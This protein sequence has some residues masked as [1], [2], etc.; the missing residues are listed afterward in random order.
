MRRAAWALALLLLAARGGLGAPAPANCISLEGERSASWIDKDQVTR[1]FS[2][3][4][5]IV[6]WEAYARITLQWDTSVDIEHVY[7]A[8]SLGQPD[9][10]S[11]VV[12][13]DAERHASHSFLVAGVGYEAMTERQSLSPRITCAS[14]DA[15]GV[16][17]P[18]PP[19]AAACDLG[20]AF[21]VVSAWAT[22][23]AVAL[24]FS[25][26]D[27]GREVRLVFWGQHGLALLQP[28][29]A[30]LAA[31][32]DV[33]DDAVLTLTLGAA[34]AEPSPPLRCV[35]S[36]ADVRTVSFQLEPPPR[37]PP[38]I[39]CLPSALPRPPPAPASTAAL[40][41]PLPLASSSLAGMAEGQP[42]TVRPDGNCALGGAASIARS[43]RLPAGRAEA[44]VVVQLGARDAAAAVVLVRARGAMLGV[45]NV[46]G[47]AVLRP[48][49]DADG[50]LLPFAVE[51]GAYAFAF[52]LHGLEGIEL[53]SMA[54]ER[55]A[56]PSLAPPPPP[57]PPPPPRGARQSEADRAAAAAEGVEEA[58]AAALF[59][60]LGGAA[61]ALCW[62]HRALVGGL[63]ARPL[64]R[65]GMGADLSAG[66]DNPNVGLFSAEEEGR[67]ACEEARV[68]RQSARGAARGAAAAGRSGSF[69]MS[70]GEEHAAAKGRRGARLAASEQDA[71]KAELREQRMAQRSRAAKAARGMLPCGSSRKGAEGSKKTK[72]EKAPAV[73]GGSALTVEE[74][75][76]GSDDALASVRVR[77]L[78]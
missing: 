70:E 49:A 29:G 11:L 38:R 13:L 14:A 51:A 43:R 23:A 56:A 4:F 5:H 7:E 78:I 21:R 45:A 35:P 26:W 39:L 74:A 27:D 16:P 2:L 33:G 18:A 31:A 65:A 17:P 76:E 34:C 67:S 59:A 57:P 1:R 77:P 63:C 22:G 32:A 60:L 72:P 3:R 55:R 53:V 12:E 69:S 36:H 52:T 8:A 28:D 68:K 73:P 61:A 15:G 6:Q 44:A 62:R 20:A 46:S 75:E 42:R 66:A 40:A 64:V 50:V 19:G 10:R 54:C 71:E 24:D 30:T 47:A 37:H 48:A 9:P 58:L 25:A 41:P